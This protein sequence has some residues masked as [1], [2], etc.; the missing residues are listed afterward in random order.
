MIESSAA[1]S[2]I[3]Q[4]SLIH[5]FRLPVAFLIFARAAQATKV[6]PVSLSP[7]K[8]Q[9]TINALEIGST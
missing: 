8:P 3:I 4:G 9:P 5:N 1:G 2:T 6:K 7:S